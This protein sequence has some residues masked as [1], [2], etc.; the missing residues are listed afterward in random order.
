MGR[1]HEQCTARPP[2]KPD[3]RPPFVRAAVIILAVGLGLLGLWYELGRQ[4]ID[5]A[6][7][8]P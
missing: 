1:W 3:L 4:G 2:M 7:Y 5:V 6:R 8:L